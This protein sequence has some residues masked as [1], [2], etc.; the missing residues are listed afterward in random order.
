MIFLIVLFIFIAELPVHILNEQ[1]LMSYDTFVQQNIQ[2]L[3]HEKFYNEI[4]LQFEYEMWVNTTLYSGVFD[5]DY[6]NVK[7]LGPI[8]FRQMRSKEIK[9][10]KKPISKD[11]KCLSHVAG[12]GDQD[13]EPFGRGNKYKWYNDNNE[14][15]STIYASSNPFSLVQYLGTGGYRID[16]PTDDPEKGWDLFEEVINDFFTER[17]AIMEVSFLQ[18]STASQLWTNTRLLLE[19]SNTYNYKASYKIRTGKFMLMTR[20]GDFFSEFI[21]IPLLIL[22]LVCL[23]VR[24]VYL[25]LLYS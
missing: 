25:N 4:T 17:T 10:E 6:T 8:R 9:C 21:E 16:V 19:V 13:K 20:F 3:V 5:W 15:Y 1:N 18:Y 11:D 23:I 14:L 24:E 12:D 7:F 2:D 22:L